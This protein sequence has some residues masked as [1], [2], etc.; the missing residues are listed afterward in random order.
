MREEVKREKIE[1]IEA[2][3]FAEIAVKTPPSTITSEAWLAA[4]KTLGMKEKVKIFVDGEEDLLVMPF[5]LEG[6]E[7]LV[8]IYGLM[9]RGF[10]LV[11]VNKS[12]KE[13]CRKL[14]GRM[15]KGL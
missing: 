2:F 4:K 11:N 8:I 1:A 5:V 14:L 3:C 12:I 13:K 10:V 7:G 9:D 15:E 6:D